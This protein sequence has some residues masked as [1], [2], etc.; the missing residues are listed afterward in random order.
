[1]FLEQEWTAFWNT[2]PHFPEGIGDEVKI[3]GPGFFCDVRYD[4]NYLYCDL[5][6]LI[7]FII[8]KIITTIK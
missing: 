2:P 6:F 3:V 4:H 5:A 8:M 7:M 1:M